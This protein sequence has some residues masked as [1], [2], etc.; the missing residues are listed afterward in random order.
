MLPFSLSCSVPGPPRNFTISVI[1]SQT[2][3]FSWKPPSVTNGV[4]LGY[5]VA[6]RSTISGI[7][8]PAFPLVV[9]VTEMEASQPQNGSLTGFFPGV[10]YNCSIAASN[11]AGNGFSAYAVVTTTEICKPAHQS[12][13]RANLWFVMHLCSVLKH[14][15]IAML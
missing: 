6:C 5:V 2:L 4:V 1:S 3:G 10:P 7:P 14:I 15:Y 13:L 9:N 8:L 12:Q 11:P